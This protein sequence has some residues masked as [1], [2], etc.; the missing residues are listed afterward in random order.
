MKNI[1]EKM[2]KESLERI[3]VEGMYEAVRSFPELLREGRRRAL[4]A[5][6][7]GWP[8]TGINGV[9]VAGLGRIRHSCGDLELLRQHGGDTCGL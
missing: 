5:E 9:V 6:T 2:T 8:G 7:R 1:S 3:D 4:K